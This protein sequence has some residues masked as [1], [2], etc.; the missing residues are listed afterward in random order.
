MPFTFSHPAAVLPFTY[1]SKRWISVTGLVIGSLS[2]DFEYFL[3]MKVYSVY[4]HTWVG[5]F[6]FDLP[7]TII[8]A[9]VFH[10]IV[11]NTLIENLPFFLKNR[12]ITFK[13][14]DW[15]KYC[16]QSFLIVIVSSIVGIATHILWDGFTHEKGQFVQAFDMLRNTFAFGKIDIPIYKL[17][18]HLSTVIGG[19]MIIY[20]VFRLPV[21]RA[22]IKQKSILPFWFSVGFIAVVIAVIRLIVSVDYKSYGNIVI[23]AITSVM[24]G[25]ILTTAFF[26]RKI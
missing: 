15:I 26:P 9:F 22:L 16:K 7:L 10:L 19:L 20:A 17:L 4:S 8:L 5:L 11:R 13:K 12:F 21:Y 3:R 14:F 25:L 18:Q 2:P 23:A 24:I 6:W 1:L